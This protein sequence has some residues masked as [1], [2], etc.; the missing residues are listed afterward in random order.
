[1]ECCIQKPETLFSELIQIK[2]GHEVLMIEK[3]LVEVDFSL[4]VV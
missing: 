1:M 3:T 2:I 4:V